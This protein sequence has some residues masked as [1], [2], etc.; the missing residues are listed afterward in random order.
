MGRFARGQLPADLEGAAFALHE[1][2]TSDVLH[3]TLGYHI[4]RVDSRTE[5]R[6]ATLDES[7]GRIRAILLRESSDQKVRQFVSA[8]M[9]RAKVNH[10]AAMLPPHRP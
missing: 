8:L 7:E 10:A 2:G 3:T 4:L 9:A 1:G 6:R 5:A